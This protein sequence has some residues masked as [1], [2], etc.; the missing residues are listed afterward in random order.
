MILKLR[1]FYHTSFNIIA[2]HKLGPYNASIPLLNHCDYCD[3]LDVVDLMM[4]THILEQLCYRHLQDWDMH[5]MDLKIA[6]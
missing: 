1:F 2:K 3:H 5:V 6:Y 4:M